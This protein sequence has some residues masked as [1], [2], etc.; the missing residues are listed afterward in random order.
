MTVFESALAGN[1]PPSAVIAANDY[2]AFGVS[3]VAQ[4][5][6][7]T[8]PIIGFDALPEA[9]RGISSTFG[10]PA[11]CAAGI[12][13]GCLG[14]EVAVWD[15]GRRGR[16]GV[17]QVADLG[18]NSGA[19][20]VRFIGQPGVRRAFINTPG[21]SAVLSTAPLTSTRVASEAHS[22]AVRCATT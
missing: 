22:A 2:M 14:N 4:A 3:E 15:L 17:V 5:N 8:M 10:P 13:P 20:E 7:L 6:G 19:L 18:A 21:T 1:N 9:N 16:R 11:A 12:E